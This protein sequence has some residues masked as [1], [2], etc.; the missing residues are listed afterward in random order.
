MSLDAILELYDQSI[1]NTRTLGA[2]QVLSEVAR[3]D[4]AKQAFHLNQDLQGFTYV[5]PWLF[6]RNR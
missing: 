2:D 3:Y 5:E 1:F 6:A 4:V